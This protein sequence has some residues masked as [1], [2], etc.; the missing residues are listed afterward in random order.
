M[1]HC[2]YA[3]VMALLLVSCV[4]EE[5]NTSTDVSAQVPET[6]NEG[7]FVQGMLNVYL[8]EDMAAEVAAS[9][10]QGT[11]VTKSADF[12]IA[13]ENLNITSIRRVYPYAGEYEE[14]LKARG[15]HRWYEI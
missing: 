10:D 9:L 1:K 12:N 8:S 6:A 2:F 7:A 11:M 5:M 13:L 15:R 4:E 14:I 3:V